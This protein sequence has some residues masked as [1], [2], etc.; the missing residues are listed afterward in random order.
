MTLNS[1]RKG[2]VLGA[3]NPIGS[4]FLQEEALCGDVSP[5]EFDEG[6]VTRREGMHPSRDVMVLRGFA[7]AELCVTMFTLH[8]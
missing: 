4:M 1:S 6:E 8:I 5:V 2:V 3:S 7:N